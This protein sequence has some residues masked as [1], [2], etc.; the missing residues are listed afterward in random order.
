MKQARH[1]SKTNE[2]VFAPKGASLWAMDNEI[3][4]TNVNNFRPCRQRKECHE[5]D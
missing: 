2:E 5:S 1:I 3:D 4:L